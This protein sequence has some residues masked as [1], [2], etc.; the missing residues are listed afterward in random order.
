MMPLLLAV[1]FGPLLA[2]KRGDLAGAAQRLY[3]F[4][5]IALARRLGTLCSC[6][7]ALPLLAA[8]GIARRRLA[9]VRRIRRCL[10]EIRPAER[11]GRR[12][13]RLSRP[14]ALGLGHRAL[15]MPGLA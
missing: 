15:P 3:V 2:W 4:A 5:G 1:P 13:A 7:P 14:A 11:A 12:L 8:F 10:A 6:H 9:A